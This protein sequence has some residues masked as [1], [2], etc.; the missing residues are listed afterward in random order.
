MARLLVG[1]TAVGASCRSVFFDAP[2]PGR[3]DH[4]VGVVVVPGFAGLSVLVS[5]AAVFGAFGGVL[6][7]AGVATRVFLGPVVVVG[8]ADTVIIIS[9]AVL[10]E[11][12]ATELAAIVIVVVLALLGMGTSV[13]LPCIHVARAGVGMFDPRL[14][15]NGANERVRGSFVAPPGVE[16]HRMWPPPVSKQLSIDATV[17]SIGV[18]LEHATGPTRNK[19]VAKNDRCFMDQ[20]LSL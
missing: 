5:G 20:F 19:I 11:I 10:P 13:A 2:V 16:T 8:F 17:V 12:K 14:R 3:A 9:G 4:V 15:V 1:T 7:S 6:S 18:P